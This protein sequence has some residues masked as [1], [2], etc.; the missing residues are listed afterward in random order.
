MFK[1]SLPFAGCEA[2]PVVERATAILIPYLNH[3]SP[4][5]EPSR[6]FLFFTLEPRVQ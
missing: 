3:S 2:L 6:L 5:P 1:D 4:I